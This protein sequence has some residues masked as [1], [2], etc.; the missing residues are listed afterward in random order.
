[1]RI[2]AK[3]HICSTLRQWLDWL[4]AQ[5][6]WW[7]IRFSLNRG[8][9]FAES[10]CEL[11]FIWQNIVLLSANSWSWVVWILTSTF[12][13]DFPPQQI[14]KYDMSGLWYIS[15][16]KYRRGLLSISYLDEWDPNDLLAIQSEDHHLPLYYT[17]MQKNIRP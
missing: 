12:W 4:Y 1:M 15:S 13:R 16:T 3:W 5:I 11:S 10:Y 8:Q 2:Q 14:E 7:L 17:L 9:L 6:S